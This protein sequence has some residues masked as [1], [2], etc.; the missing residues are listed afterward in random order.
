MSK[1][2]K[3]I[4]FYLVV[5]ALFTP[6]LVDIHTYFP[7]I[8]A[9]ATVFR[10]LTE[11][12]LVVWVLWLVS[13]KRI[14]IPLTPLSKAVLIFGVIVFISALLGIDFH[15]SFFSGNERMGGVFGFW[16]FILFFLVISTVFNW[17][18]IEKILQI[19]VGIGLVYSFLALLAYKGIGTIT[20]KFTSN[21]LA[22]YTGNPSYF[23]TYLIFNSFL[24][25]YFYF[26]QF[27]KD[28]KIFNWWLLI[29]AFQGIL[30]FIT[31]CR[32]ALMSYLFAL[33][34]VSGGIIFWT[35]EK[36]PSSELGKEVRS[37]R[38]WVIVAL[39]GIV[40]LASVIYS[41]KNT[42]FVQKNIA[43]K[44]FTS[45]S[46][47]AP[48]A[49]SRIMSAGDAWRAFLK[50]PL[51]GW[52]PENYE[53]AYITNFNPQ[54]LK[55]LPNDFYFDRA[56]NKP[57]QVLANN[58]I[59]GFLSYLSIFIIALWQL[60]KLR[61]KKE[62]LLPALAL[63][64]LVVAYFGQNVFLFD[65]HESYLMLFL[66]LAF[67]TS[68]ERDSSSVIRRQA[69]IEKQASTS[70]IDYSSQL[71][72]YFLVIGA[73]CLVIFTS[74]Q[75]VIRPYQVSH[76]IFAITYQLRKGDGQ[77]AYQILRRTINHPAFLEED[78]VIG[79]RKALAA[80]PH[81]IDKVSEKKIVNL[82]LEASSSILKKEPWRYRLLTTHGELEL[83]A[84]TWNKKELQEAKKTARKILA[85][86]PNFPNSH[87]FAAK[88]LLMN[89]NPK[90]A[91]EEAKKALTLDPRNSTGYYMLAV[92]YE[93]L[94][95]ATST[96]E[97]LIKAAQYHFPFSSKEIILQVVELLAERKDY[98]TIAA[99]YQRAIQLDPKDASLYVHLAATYGKLHNKEKA[100]KYAREAAKLNPKFK[101][102]SED[103]IRLIQKEE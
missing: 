24:A 77:Q 74:T 57:M 18:E 29:S 6:F 42:S 92:A 5:A 13:K 45:I 87:L 36:G 23:A 59:F 100:I 65:F 61:K 86:A 37:L 22:G 7:F 67:I 98:Q 38:R 84:S 60:N 64:G 25:L 54:V 11:V 30:I 102:A 9:K 35:R 2:L 46:L 49:V 96:K 101:Q 47:K 93:E 41:L 33:F 88:T 71:G 83:I 28:K 17:R 66:S 21:R 55:Y 3:T 73:I 81:K 16:H 70:N 32:G 72:R 53:A 15:F 51:F 52:G 10:L 69:L 58:G 20:A 14:H 68:L 1:S 75:W 4:L 48:T 27:T 97:N 91:M 78:V 8:I 94:G 44:R 76:N 43:L 90:G 39:L 85:F 82:L 80:Y 56:H 103:F 62:W 89:K 95:K 50:K 40:I 12:M 19:Q 34:L 79:T 31:G 26:R 99:L 63:G